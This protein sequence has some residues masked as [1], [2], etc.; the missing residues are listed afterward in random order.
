MSRHLLPKNNGGVQIIRNGEWIDFSDKFSSFSENIELPKGARI[1]VSS[2]P[3]PWARM[4]LIKDAVANRNH[5][6]HLESMSHIL[7][8]L[9]LIFFQKSLKFSLEIKEIVIQ[10]EKFPHH[11]YK[12]LYDLHP[13]A[14]GEEIIKI[15]LLLAV[16][17][18][19]NSK[20]VLAGTSDHS[21]FF[22]P[23]D[24]VNSDK[25]TRYFRLKPRMLADR[26]LVFQKWIKQV[27]IPK[28]TIS[29]LTPDLINALRFADGIC[30][31]SSDDTFE[32]TPYARSSL[33]EGL[34]TYYEIFDQYTGP[35]ES[36]HL[37]RTS[38]Q[39]P[40]PP[41][42]I[43]TATHLYDR[44]YYNG[45]KFLTNF[46]SNELDAL[47]RNT[48]PGEIVKYP[49]VLPERDFL[50]P[51][52]IRY[53]YAFNKQVLY[54]GND[55]NEFRYLL[56]LTEKFF[57]YFSHEDVD[58]MISIS[59]CGLNCVKVSLIIPLV[60]DTIVQIEKMYN[61]K[62][63][64][65]SDNSCIIEYDSLA[66]QTPLPYP[67]FWP[68][69]HPR[70]WNSPYYC[71]IS[72]ER[73]KEDVELVNIQFLDD[74]FSAIDALPKRKSYS[75]EVFELEKLPTYV[76]ITDIV[77]GVSGF[78]IIKHKTLPI[79]ELEHDAR[80]G[81][82]FG[83]SHTTFAI[84]VNDTQEILRNK[85][86]YIKNNLNT[87]EFI[88]TVFFNENE[89]S[90]A[91]LI[92][93]KANLSQYLYPNRLGINNTE[94]ETSFPMPTMVVKEQNIPEPRP[95]LHYSINFS[96]HE[97]YP[98]AT[99]AR[100]VNSSIVSMTDLKW[101][102]DPVNQKASEAYLKI[103]LN[104]LRFELIK[105]NINPDQSSYY[106]AYPRSFSD[107]NKTHYERMWSNLL[108]G[109][110]RKNTDESKAALL[111]FE[112]IGEVSPRNPNIVIVADIGGGSSDVSVWKR[113]NILLL[114]SSR[115]AGRDIVGY[116]DASGFHSTILSTLRIQFANIASNLQFNDDPFTELNYMLYSIPEKELSNGILNQ[117]FRKVRFLIVYFYSSLLYEIGLQARRFIDVD[118]SSVDICLAGNG[119]NFAL[120]SGEEQSINDME[121][122]IYKKIL[123][124]ALKLDDNVRIRFT[125]SNQNAKKTEVAIGLCK[126]NEELFEQD[127]QECPIIAD[128]IFIDGNS[129]PQLLPIEEFNKSFSSKNNDLRINQTDSELLKFHNL[130]FEVIGATELYRT[131]LR[132][133]NSLRNLNDIKSELLDDW[134]NIEGSII[135]MIA[136]NLEVLN[137]ITSS[138]FILGMKATIKKLHKY[139]ANN[140]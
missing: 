100:A 62:W 133:D 105:R 132:Q 109:V 3:S 48:L 116:R 101:N 59:E 127:A 41:L 135:S 14:D 71:I 115:W 98:Y 67:I 18:K 103:L 33:F 104:L 56:P 69:L 45:Y 85:E 40:K 4:L 38:S 74:R 97:L 136:E 29:R 70:M 60:N 111:Y 112:H 46:E 81:I 117:Y 108:H 78:L 94:E 52:I 24:L 7:D 118:T 137:S 35:L 121:K 88:T 95:I 140:R 20:F 50:A 128:N 37:I 53:K 68:K 72:A 30:A 64:N 55:T 42:F 28:L 16:N 119:S 73:Y 106:W 110:R 57:E 66:L 36:E 8:I 61:G 93:I 15:H 19:N 25:V 82:D 123:M 43:N 91:E 44:P 83:T 75:I 89:L 12:I 124:S 21:L 77:S 102:S 32:Y 79:Y 130:F 1:N 113:G 6:L 139:L 96:K 120:W 49:W 65:A 2:I 122:K 34:D 86:P 22:T 26:P 84:N 92:L 13:S 51:N 80:I 47:D 131:D 107:T 31:N 90:D 76:I 125:S 9:E 17:P 54:M 99:N 27:F 138:I 87:N 114:A 134:P 23:L 5:V 10:A 58:S 63:T 129:V 126:G 39:M 11:F